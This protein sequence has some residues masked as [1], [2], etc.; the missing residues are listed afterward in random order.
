MAKMIYCRLGEYGTFYNW[1]TLANHDG[2][3]DVAK[4]KEI[5]WAGQYFNTCVF[6]LVHFLAVF[7][8][9]T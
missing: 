4:K 6:N 3:E 9:T 5:S 2:N 8:K 7:C 1:G